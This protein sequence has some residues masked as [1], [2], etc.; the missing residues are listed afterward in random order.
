MNAT[1]T[2]SAAT[3]SRSVGLL[4]EAYSWVACSSG[5][6]PRLWAGWGKG[7]AGGSGH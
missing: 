7:T 4:L 3:F 5:R 6:T 1:A 2:T